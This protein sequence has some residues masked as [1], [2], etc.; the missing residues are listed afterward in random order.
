MNKVDDGIEIIMYLFPKLYRK[1]I[2]DL[3]REYNKK[4]IYRSSR[5]VREDAIEIVWFL[6]GQELFDLSDTHS[7]RGMWSWQEEK[8][9]SLAVDHCVVTQ[10]RIESYT[11]HDIDCEK[12]YYEF[13]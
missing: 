6:F 10:M 3:R 5:G 8:N 7:T 2:K 9:I 13:W 4:H 12:I 1:L 11:Q